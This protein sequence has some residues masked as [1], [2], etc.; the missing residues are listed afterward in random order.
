MRYGG[1]SIGVATS[2]FVSLRTARSPTS[3]NRGPRHP[4]LMMPR[5][6]NP[7]EKVDVSGPC[8]ADDCVG[9][10]HRVG[11]AG[12]TLHGAV[13]EHR[14]VATLGIGVVVAIHDGALR[15]RASKQ[16]HPPT[17]KS[18]AAA[19]SSSTVTSSAGSCRNAST[20]AGDDVAHFPEPRSDCFERRR[21]ARAAARLGG[22]PPA[23]RPS[24]DVPSLA[25]T[26]GRAGPTLARTSS[27]VPPRSPCRQCAR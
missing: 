10:G 23:A 19:G 18:C 14:A 27:S 6:M 16:R 11:P 21:P 20:M 24:S 17:R 22:Q 3:K 13:G 2:R 5:P 4:S 1:R 9:G 8:L 15:M 7:H 26:P 25:A 12:G